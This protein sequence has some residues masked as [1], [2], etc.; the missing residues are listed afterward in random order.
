MNHTR[1]TNAS[2]VIAN[3]YS[4]TANYFTKEYVDEL[5]VFHQRERDA[6]RSKIYGLESENEHL[7]EELKIQTDSLER[8]CERT[9]YQ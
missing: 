3:S 4:A 7:M 5:I 2:T 8:Q 6:F 9:R 1:E